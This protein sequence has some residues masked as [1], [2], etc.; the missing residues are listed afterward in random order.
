MVQVG[1]RS[2]LLSLVCRAAAWAGNAD[3]YERCEV[4]RRSIYEVRK[5]KRRAPRGQIGSRTDGKPQQAR[6]PTAPRIPP[7]TL[8]P[9]AGSHNFKRQE[10][11]NKAAAEVPAP[12]PVQ[13]T[14]LDPIA[15]AVSISL[16]NSA[17]WALSS[18]SASF[19]GEIFA[20]SSQSLIDV[21]AASSA[22]GAS[23][24]AVIT[25]AAAAA[26]SLVASISS[27]A[28]AA[29][30]SIAASASNAIEAAQAS[31]QGTMDSS[32][33]ATLPSTPASSEADSFLVTPSQI[34][35]IIIGTVIGTAIITL[36]IVY[37]ISL[38]RGRSAKKYADKKLDG[39]ERNSPTT[40]DDSIALDPLPSESTG[41]ANGYLTR[42]EK[43]LI[44]LPSNT[45]PVVSQR[46]Q[47]SLRQ[48]PISHRPS[49]PPLPEESPRSSE[50]LSLYD[51]GGDASAGFGFSMGLTP[52]AEG[53]LDTAEDE[54][55]VSLELTQRRSVGGTK[56][57]RTVKVRSAREVNKTH[58]KRPASAAAEN[59]Y[60]NT[61]SQDRETRNQACDPLQTHQL[62]R[63]RATIV[64]TPSSDT[65]PHTLRSDFPSPLTLNPPTT[66]VS[67]APQM[68][69]LSSWKTQNSQPQQPYPQHR[70]QNHIAFLLSQAPTSPRQHLS[71]SPGVNGKQRRDTFS[72]SPISPY[73]ST[74]GPTPLVSPMFVSPLSPPPKNPL[75]LIRQSQSEVALRNALMG[76]DGTRNNEADT[77]K[78]H[79]P[80]PL[81][82]YS[83]SD[84]ELLTHA[85]GQFFE[86]QD[87]EREGERQDSVGRSR[88][89]SGSVSG[90]VGG[91]GIRN[92]R[93]TFF[94][95][96]G[97]E[98]VGSSS[99]TTGSARSRGSAAS[100]ETRGSLWSQRRS[101]SLNDIEYVAGALEEGRGGG[102]GGGLLPGAPGGAELAVTMPRFS[103]FPSMEAGRA[104][105]NLSS[106]PTSPRGYHARRSS[107]SKVEYVL[108]NERNEDAYGSRR[109]VPGIRSLQDSWD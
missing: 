56:R 84:P 54:G 102:P 86:D 92:G 96:Y 99:S 77:D 23:A 57:T 85:K 64:R 65:L 101:N 3:S 36:S 55:P 38:C 26:T 42:E 24:G 68:P 58:H 70:T 95:N 10:P 93:F 50:R 81:R 9:E 51:T 15:S 41:R 6:H 48:H 75:R 39:D 45:Q 53:S 19:Q 40:Y 4:E 109:L 49:L 46:Q 18:V 60:F 28:A 79:P 80:L 69:A 35:A 11:D 89:G 88:S 103:L 59:P 32:P 22:A 66:T 106:P 83:P 62:T 16:T 71:I 94:P 14:T 20:L 67:A 82:R 74:F 8:L 2:S 90:T 27:S 21:A 73:S 76:D 7:P 31:A 30:S 43:Q 107:M 100:G 47:P 87:R 104:S 97:L 78:A 108:G 105:A 34:A 17:S 72:I 12:T 1:A 98:P 25:S 33:T 91:H 13:S 63:D 52:A 44:N 5:R 61:K 37:F 29:S